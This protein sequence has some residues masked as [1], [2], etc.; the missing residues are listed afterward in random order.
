MFRVAE[1]DH[2]QNDENDE[3][4]TCQQLALSTSLLPA[5]TSSKKGSHWTK[6][7]Y[8]EIHDISRHDINFHQLFLG[9]QRCR[10]FSGQDP[11]RL[12]SVWA[13]PCQTANPSAPSLGSVGSP[14][15]LVL[16]QIFGRIVKEKW[17][18]HRKWMLDAGGN[19]VMTWMMIICGDGSHNN[20]KN[21]PSLLGPKLVA[22]TN[23]R[24]AGA[25]KPPSTSNLR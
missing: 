15:W 21:H 14:S 19:M 4:D 24:R 23:S 16:L 2:D 7:V 5:T 17:K 13:P 1:G 12:P 9:I 6:P 8:E 22:M 3:T 10:I 11:S 18:C 20:S 25:P